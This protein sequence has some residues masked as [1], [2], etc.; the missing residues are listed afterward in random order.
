MK[1]IFVFV[2]AVLAAVCALGSCGS[3]TEITL[4]AGERL[5]A[6]SEGSWSVFAY[7]CGNSGDKASELISSLCTR[8]YP[9]NVNFVIQTG[10][11]ADCGIEDVNVDYLQRF[12]PQDGSLF[13]ADQKQPASMGDYR[14]LADF[15]SWGVQ[16]YPA[17]RYMVLLVGD[18]TGTETLGDA[19]FGGDSL[20]VEELSYA[21][22]LAG[23]RF[24]LV[25]FD[26]AYCSSYEIAS[27]LS[28]YAGFMLASEEKCAGFDY[29]RLADVLVEYPY[30]SPQELGQLMCD[31]YFE[32]CA[33]EGV[34]RMA[35]MALT[36]LS[37]IS[38]LAQAFDGM[39]AVMASTTDGLDTYGALARNALAAQSCVGSGDMVDL[40]SLAAAI[41]DNVGEPSQ[42]VVNAVAQT[43][44]YGVRGDLRPM[45]NGLSVYY[46]QDID[47]QTLIDYMTAT[48]S[49][50]YKLFLK[51][52]SPG[53]EAADDFVT[54]DYRDS[55]A[56]CD[57]VGREFSIS[58][59]MSDDQR[60]A[61]AINGDMSI[62]K[63]VRLNRYFYYPDSNAYYSM[64]S[65]NNLDCD[66]E[67][68][69]YMDNVTPVAP[70]I[71][72]Q[73]VQADLSDEIKDVGKL[74]TVPVLIND[75]MGEIVL[76]YSWQS[77]G[78]EIAGVWQNGD[79][80]EP[81]S[82]DRVATVHR[83]MEEEDTLLTGKTFRPFFGLKVKNKSLSDG[84]YVLEYELEDVYSLV[85]RAVPAYMER[86]GGE[87]RI[88]QQ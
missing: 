41:A 88:Y 71:N 22:S 69:R 78:Y 17:D 15:L 60:Y 56:W 72:G 65:D 64:G 79:T 26:G 50:S 20:T 32:K 55:W 18:G 24:D 6:A 7:V 75:E 11:G 87:M 38:Q 76:F 70:E 84:Q 46:P 44:I 9:A 35:A 86:D 4:E 73:L 40:A 39:A 42:G 62:V 83:I 51:S 12:I 33:A 47:E 27:S 63:D 19:L 25:A 67:N 37:H 82:G 53:V 3:N 1:K 77:G 45:A 36:D 57:Y 28:P 80:A 30:V 10:G 81:G 21:V 43:V 58:S 59:Y 2:C 74:Y 68:G 14:T 61:L 48:T 13:L 52:I 66:W 29:E 23:A 16:T 54:A 85:R 34:D 8:D 31:D 49:D 5:P